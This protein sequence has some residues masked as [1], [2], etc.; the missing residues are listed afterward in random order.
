[1]VDHD[2]TYFLTFLKRNSI[3]IMDIRSEIQELK[4]LEEHYLKL[5]GIQRNSDKAI[6][7]FHAWYKALLVFFNRIIPAENEDFNQKNKE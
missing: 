4:E 3:S 7:A 1:M 6:K 5:C 2:R